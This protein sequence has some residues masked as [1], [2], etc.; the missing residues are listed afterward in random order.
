MG[1]KPLSAC[2]VSLFY[3]GFHFTVKHLKEWNSGTYFFLSIIL[4][5]FA[6]CSSVF[7]GI[8]MFNQ[9]NWWVLCKFFGLVDLSKLN[10]IRSQLPDMSTR[11]GGFIELNSEKRRLVRPVWGNIVL[12]S[13][14]FFS[15]LCLFKCVHLYLVYDGC[16]LKSMVTIFCAKNT[17]KVYY[18]LKI[19]LMGSVF[20]FRLLALVELTKRRKVIMVLNC[21]PWKFP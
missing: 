6:S 8:L 7:M 17:I 20:F 5:V 3:K 2:F 12:C 13:W 11:W 15:G 21:N 14:P 10:V 9:Q 4:V 19:R 16:T 18:I 1:F